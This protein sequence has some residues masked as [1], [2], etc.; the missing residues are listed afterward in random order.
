M[1]RFELD[2]KVKDMGLASEGDSSIEWAQRN[3]P[4]LQDI[5]RQFGEN[6]SFEGVRIA[7]CLHITK[8]TAALMLAFQEGG[9][10]VTLCP[11][12]PLST[13][14]DV[15]ASLANRGIKVYGW[16]G[17]GTEDY[18]WCISKAT[19]IRPQILL[20]DGADLISHLH[21][22]NPPIVPDFGP[23]PPRGREAY[24]KELR[25]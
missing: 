22:E 19:E 25:N 1:W 7:A 24:K 20:D 13:Q 18:Y 2:F 14:D 8:E 11:S 23:V 4:V 21:K 16:K 3:M 6:G 12:N 9:A 15:A 5:S 17:I 10:E